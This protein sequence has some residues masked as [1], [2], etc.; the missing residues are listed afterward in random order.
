MYLVNSSDP[1]TYWNL[2]LLWERPEWL[3]AP[4][5]PDVSK[6]MFWVPIV[7]WWT[8]L[9][10]MAFSTGVPAGHGHQYGPNP[11][12]AWASV[13]QPPGWTPQKTEQLREIMKKK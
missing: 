13:T 2:K 11:V 3:D 5:G 7:T 8:T 12:D 4:R 6:H 9:G 1:I 10:D